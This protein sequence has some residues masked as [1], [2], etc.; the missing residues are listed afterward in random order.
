MRVLL[1]L[2][3]LQPEHDHLQVC[4]QR[5]RGHREHAPLV[6]VR[7]QHA[8]LATRELVVEGLRGEVHER[9][10]VGVLLGLDV[11]RR[12]R[13]DVSLDVA[14]E[15]LLVLLA[16]DVVLRVE[17]PLEVVE[18]ELRV[19]RDESVDADHGVDALAAAE[20]VLERVGGRRQP[21]KERC[22]ELRGLGRASQDDYSAPRRVR[23]R[24]EQHR[25]PGV[26]LR[27]GQ[28]SGNGQTRSEIPPNHFGGDRSRARPVRGL[29]N[30][31]S[32]IR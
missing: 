21:V 29:F 10:V 1:D 3:P 24:L 22:V 20:A 27:C 11:L 30:R 5:R 23:S 31:K 17:H 4:G 28:F 32:R 16:L 25:H 19:D 2:H 9:E 14:R 7:E 13:V 8:G 12:D 6:R 26:W 15:C 18:R